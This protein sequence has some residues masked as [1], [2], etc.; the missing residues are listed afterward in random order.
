MD[1]LWPAIGI[2]AIVCF[3]FYVLASHWRGVLQ[4]QTR[5]IRHLRNACTCLKK[6]VIPNFAV[7][8]ENQRP[9]LSNRFLN[10]TFR[11]DDRFWHENLHIL[12]EDWDSFAP[13]A[14]SS[15]R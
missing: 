5:I 8:S 10:F 6:W 3:V 11:M 7:A 12:K 4:H 15:A 1:I 9:C 13:Q 2:A 14:R